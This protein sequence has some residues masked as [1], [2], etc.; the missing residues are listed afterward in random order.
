MQ[1]REVARFLFAALAD[2]LG[3]L[4][5]VQEIVEG[6]SAVLLFE[7]SIGERTAQGVNVLQQPPTARSPNSRP[8]SAHSTPCS[9]S[10]TS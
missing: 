2:E 5:P 10:P 1:G 6:R 3:P 9:A 8:S 4:R 7:T